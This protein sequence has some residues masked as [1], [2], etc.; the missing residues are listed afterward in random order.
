[1]FIRSFQLQKFLPTK[2]SFHCFLIYKLWLVLSATRS[3]PLC[4]ISRSPYH[5]VDDDDFEALA[6]PESALVA[7]ALPW[8]SSQLS[9][10]R[11]TPIY[12]R[13]KSRYRD[14][15]PKRHLFWLCFIGV[16][17]LVNDE[18]FLKRTKR[19]EIIIFFFLI[20]LHLKPH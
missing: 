19:F 17:A 9:W 16:V 3:S 6:A 12:D 8:C 11:F 5:D 14:L 18:R 20:W 2:I 7:V 4:T 13:H 10:F 1:M 15:R